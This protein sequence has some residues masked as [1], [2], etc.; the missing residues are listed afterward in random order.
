ML[1]HPNEIYPELND[2]LINFCSID[3]SAMYSVA[4]QLLN[5]NIPSKD[6]LIECIKEVKSN[7]YIY[8]KERTFALKILQEITYGKNEKDILTMKEL[9]NIFIKIVK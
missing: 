6:E 1:Q 5:G 3:C 7:E 9:K 8:E 4:T 2:I